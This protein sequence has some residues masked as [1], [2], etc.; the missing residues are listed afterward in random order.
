M[1][2]LDLLALSPDDLSSLTNRGTVKRAQRE[3]VD[4]ALEFEIEETDTALTVN[5]S[6]GTTCTFPAEETIH[7]AV[8]SSGSLGISRH[9]V[10]SVLAYQRV[11]QAG[12][13]SKASTPRG[14]EGAPAEEQPVDAKPGQAVESDWDPGSVS[15]QELEKLFRKATITKARKVF[16]QGVLVEL[17][18][19]AKPT[20]RFLHESCTVRFPV[21]GDIRYAMAD[22]SDAQL[23]QWVAISVWSFRHFSTAR[24]A[25]LLSLQHVEL[26][27][28]R[29]E[30]DQLSDL[31]L[32]FCTD[33][34]SGINA[35]WHQRL[36]RLEK[37]FRSVGLVWPAELL[38]DLLDQHQRYQ[39]QD[40]RFSPAEVVRITGELIARSRAIGAQSGTVGN[41]TNPQSPHKIFL[42]GP[43]QL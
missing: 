7:Q 12:D 10:R 32:E 1:A 35:T 21:P 37:Q 9:V 23:P 30:L 26:P 3:L 25:G 6:D 29:E 31:L 41:K 36:T 4:G 27:T 39:Q 16:E 42:C 2:R 24:V 11:H 34:M 33:G 8:C 28:P 43:V 14:S 17:T 19:G 22:C 20:A 5:W 18:R 40:A 13:E 38:L 15:D